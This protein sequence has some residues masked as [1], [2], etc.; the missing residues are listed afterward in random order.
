V[1]DQGE[2]SSLGIE[3]AWHVEEHIERL[4]GVLN[5][6]QGPSLNQTARLAEHLF[7]VPVAML[8][9]L[10]E[11]SEC[12]EV[13]G[14]GGLDPRQFTGLI[15]AR[16]GPL[17]RMVVTDTR[18]GVPPDAEAGL[19]DQTGIRAFVTQSL[20]SVDGID[21]RVLLIADTVARPDLCGPAVDLLAD[22]A[23]IIVTHIEFRITAARMRDA[24]LR[25]AADTA[26]V[27]LWVTAA[28]GFYT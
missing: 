9:F 15:G 13:F 11:A 4:R 17:Q 1:A 16:D 8:G 3:S 18:R 23:A 20:F 6:P 14:V 26:P 24:N 21:L 28:G 2:V 27:L 7:R 12:P 22:L 25:A 10:D 19:F 5:S